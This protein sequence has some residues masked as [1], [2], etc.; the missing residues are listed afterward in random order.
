MLGIQAPIAPESAAVCRTVWWRLTAG[1][2]YTYC[3]IGTGR[4]LSQTC[5]QMEGCHQ[6]EILRTKPLAV[7]AALFLIN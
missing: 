3:C 1:G 6:I 7:K 5:Y 2:A 4:T